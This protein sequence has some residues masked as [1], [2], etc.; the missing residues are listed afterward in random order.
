MN[1][2]EKTN[3]TVVATVKPGIQQLEIIGV[4]DKSDEKGNRVLVTFKTPNGAT[5]NRMFF[6]KSITATDPKEMDN[7]YNHM[8]LQLGYEENAK[9]KASDV[10]KVGNKFTGNVAYGTTAQGFTKVYVNITVRV[11][12]DTVEEPIE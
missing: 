10:L 2:L 6:E 11:S 1:W 3:S 12:V 9:V 5:I 7:D 8:L 4:E